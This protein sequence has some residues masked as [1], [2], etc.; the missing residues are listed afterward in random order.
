MWCSVAP[1]DHS[2]VLLSTDYKCGHNYLLM[3]TMETQMYE[4]LLFCL[5]K[6]TINNL[7]YMNLIILT[8]SVEERKFEE[9]VELETN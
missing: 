8:P 6:K 3:N 5:G 2:V 4:Q 7:K 9:T 1:E